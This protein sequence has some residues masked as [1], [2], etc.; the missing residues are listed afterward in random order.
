M[1][2]YAQ[3]SAILALS[4]EKFPPQKL[5][6]DEISISQKLCKKVLSCVI[7]YAEN[8]ELDRNVEMQEL[9]K[10]V[11]E[12]SVKRNSK[13]ALRYVVPFYI[14]YTASLI[15]ANPLPMLI[16]FGVLNAGNEGIE[17]ENKNLTSIAK[18]TDRRSD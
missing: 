14:G 11:E 13:A 6:K 12:Y 17:N 10:P 4:V 18:E 2:S 1:G 9:L 16:G 15:T 5:H 3:L 8:H 7:K